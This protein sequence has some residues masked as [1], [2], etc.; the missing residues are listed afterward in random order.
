MQT[1]KNIADG[2]RSRDLNNYKAD[3]SSLRTSR[4]MLDLASIN[5][6]TNQ[7]EID[8][9]NSAYQTGAAPSGV[10]PGSVAGDHVDEESKGQQ[11]D[12]VE[13]RSIV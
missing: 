9:P 8:A 10:R 1:Q 3:E 12:L 7:Q 11:S 5:Q 2:E 6:N 4:D 13:A